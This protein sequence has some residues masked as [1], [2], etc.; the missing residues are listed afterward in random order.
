MPFH[1]TLL[2]IYQGTD[3]DDPINNIT[4]DIP[5]I[6]QIVNNIS[7]AMGSMWAGESRMVIAHAPFQNLDGIIHAG[8]EPSAP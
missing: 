8:K 7:T 5:Y 2:G 4:N 6:Y 3:E 1:V